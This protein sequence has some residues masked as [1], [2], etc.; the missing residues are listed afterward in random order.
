M[1]TSTALLEV[2]EQLKEEAERTPEIIVPFPS[3]NEYRK[4]QQMWN[5]NWSQA[6]AMDIYS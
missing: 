3:W 6:A 5:P 1:S 4:R 2:L